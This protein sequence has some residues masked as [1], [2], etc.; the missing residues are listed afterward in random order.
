[1][2]KMKNAFERAMERVTS[3]G[4]ATSEDKLRFSWE[5]K[6][7]KKASEFLNGEGNLTEFVETC[8]EETRYLVIEGIKQV[9][10]NNIVLPEDEAQ[11]KRI[12]K[13]I[14]GLEQTIPNN[15]SL[16]EILERINYIVSSLLSYRQDKLKEVYEQFKTRFESTVRETLQQQ[17]QGNIQPDMPL[18]VEAMP[19]FGQEW[20]KVRM[21]FESLNQATLD[22]QKKLLQDI[23]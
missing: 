15:P 8:D 10:I 19:Q 21:Q 22:E 11:M 13:A 7:R 9:L 1:M 18:N 17:G 16:K 6:G 2:D 20:N 23:S 5:P 4:D 3:L 12:T 14:E